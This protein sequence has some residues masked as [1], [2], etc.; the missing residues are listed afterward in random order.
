MVQ[1][2][3]EAPRTQQARQ[4]LLEAGRELLL[5]VTPAPGPVQSPEVFL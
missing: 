1:S 5:D 3:G 2:A 4:A